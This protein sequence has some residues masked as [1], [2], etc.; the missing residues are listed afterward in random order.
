MQ[1]ILQL[2]ARYGSHFLFLGLEIFC[3]VLIV[4]FNK[5]QKEIYLNSINLLNGKLTERVDKTRD[6][7]RLQEINDS[8]T[9]ENSR[10]IQRLINESSSNLPNLQA[11]VS[12]DYNIIPALVCDKTINLKNNYITLCKGS[13]DGVKSG[14]GVIAEKGVVGLVRSVSN[15]F[16]IVL[17]I[18]NVL[19]RTS[20]A[21]KGSNYFG[22]MKWQDTNP[23]KMI[24]EEV[25]KHAQFSAGDT[26]VT[27][28]YSTVFPKGIN[29]GKVTNFYVEPGSANFSIEIEVNEDLARLEYAYI[30]DYRKKEQK[31]SLINLVINE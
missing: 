17:P 21:I 4:N 30:I 10:L 12:Q 26:I 24:V 14:M 11:E 18:I 13:K 27:S 5:T 9:A 25:P 2:F 8:L 19:S 31:D 16:S 1:N 6:Y 15:D 28:G 23:L 20:V 22:T 7:L 29:I 3:F